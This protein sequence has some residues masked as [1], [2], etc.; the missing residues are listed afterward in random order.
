MSFMA[1]AGKPKTPRTRAGHG[2]R[3]AR[4]ARFEDE[5]HEVVGRLSRTIRMI[6]DAIPQHGGI[7]R[8]AELERALGIGT[9]LAWQIFRTA[10]AAESIIDAGNIPGRTGMRR[11][12]EAAGKRRVPKSLIAAASKALEEF[13]GLIKDHATD[14]QAFSS[15]LSALESEGAEPIDVPRRR[16]A[17]KAMSDILGV[18]AKV[19]LACNIQQPSSNHPDRVDNAF[20]RGFHGLR[21]LRANAP[22]ILA[23][24]RI[25]DT[26]GKVLP[27]QPRPLDLADE[28]D[29]QFSLLRKFCTTPM[30]A[31]RTVPSDLGFMNIEV[32][33]NDI[34]NRSAVTC[35]TGEICYEAVDRYHGPGNEW[36]GAHVLVRT[37]CELL[38]IDMLIRE[39]TYRSIAPR[40]SVFT[41]HACTEPCMTPARER[42]RLPQRESVEYLGK[43]AQAL[44][45]RHVPRHAEMMQYAFDQLGWNAAKFDVYQCRVE[46]PIVP[47]SVVVSFDLPEKPEPGDAE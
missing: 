13:L 3:Q 4:S 8:P 14:R 27:Q 32:A 6:I 1:T 16:A 31:L 9:T 2:S 28:T 18:Q 20:L 29:A 30:P 21:R 37:P 38:V 10:N 7:H 23:R 40:V 19:Q 11:F 12:F 46:Y 17:Y 47:S 36:D 33:G 24:T 45:N 41:D 25:T 15:M 26:A 22:L 35:F 34:G 5:L 43:A 42:D 39:D 44:S